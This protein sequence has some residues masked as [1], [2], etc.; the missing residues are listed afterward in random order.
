MAL[1]CRG[2]DHLKFDRMAPD[3]CVGSDF[4]R[5]IERSNERTVRT[6]SNRSFERSVRTVRSFDPSI[7]RSK[8][9]A[10]RESIMKLKMLGMRFWMVLDAEI[11]NQIKVF[12][13]ATHM[14]Q[15]WRNAFAASEKWRNNDFFCRHLIWSRIFT[16]R[17]ALN[18]EI[19]VVLAFC[20][21]AFS[22]HVAVHCILEHFDMIPDLRLENHSESHPDHLQFH[23]SEDFRFSIRRSWIRRSC[24][25]IALLFGNS[26]FLSSSILVWFQIFA[27]KDRSNRSFE[28]RSGIIS[29]CPKIQC[30]ATCLQKPELNRYP[31]IENH[32]NFM[33]QSDSRSGIRSTGCSRSNCTS[34]TI[35]K[36]S[37]RSSSISWSILASSLI[38]NGRM[39]ELFERT[40]RTT[41]SN[42]LFERT[43]R[44]RSVRTVC[45]F[46][47]STVRN[48]RRR[49]NREPFGQM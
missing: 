5:S 28:R 30:T 1:P 19:K 40:V 16:S 15:I 46:D 20:K 34:R 37:F 13:N 27:S 2:S 18:H 22:G 11:R 31:R 33:I 23:D 9:E 44:T 42:G 6:G 3:S 39:N 45:S 32:F 12:Q 41:G 36:I 10:T 4:E 43:V 24:C 35:Q 7:D 21:I 49:E 38:S 17:I 25:K 48:Q 47:R 14:L 29:K 8:S 26:E